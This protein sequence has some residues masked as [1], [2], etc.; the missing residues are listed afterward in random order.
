V[1]LVLEVEK[2]EEEELLDV[3]QPFGRAHAF[4]LQRRSFDYYTV[5]TEAW[6]VTKT[7]DIEVSASP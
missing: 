4:F 3:T 2:S 7:Y 1:R 5:G 6:A